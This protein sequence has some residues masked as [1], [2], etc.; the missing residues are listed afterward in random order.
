VNKT[1]DPRSFNIM[2]RDTLALVM[3]G[4]RGTRLKELTL[5]RAKPATPFGG[6]F[7]IIDFTL[8]NC[9]NS[10]L[11]RIGVLTQYKSH[12]LIH[13]LH[14]GWSFLHSRF[15]EFVKIMPADQNETND[16][17]YKG[18]ADAIYQNIDFIQM[19]RPKRVLVLAGDHIYKMDYG[20]MLRDHIEA[21]ADCTVGCVETPLEEATEFGVVQ[22]NPR[23]WVCK[24]EEKSPNPSPMPGNPDVALASMG[25]YVFETDFLLEELKR[26]AADP[27][28]SHDFGKDI[29]PRIINS[30]KV[31]VHRFRD[32]Y[33]ESRPGFWR[34]VGTLDAYW[35]ANMELLDVTPEF[36]M[37]DDQ[38]PIW[39]CPEQL[40][41]AKFVLNNSSA[42]GMAVD[43][44]VTSGCIISGAKVERSIF[45]ESARVGNRSNVKESLILPNAEVGRDCRITRAIIDA[46]CKIPDGMVIGESPEQ[47]SRYFTRTQD[48]VVLVT[49]EMLSAFRAD[50][51]ASKPSVH[52][53]A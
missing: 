20:Q 33:D 16:S 28:S 45:F 42:R 47:D 5:Q 27:D 44:L 18:T 24:F 9:I 8:S 1:V 4:G 26:D 6:K 10:G 22:V 46:D 25:I 30:A 15:G 35:K 32:M 52:L 2:T 19:H 39:T 48:G 14:A 23:K 51:E 29:L 11:C 21:G 34:D 17:W 40:P 38:W 7:R 50:L 37:Y 53:S 12:S 3:A 13:H 43:S 31:T 41:P 49:Q 36:N